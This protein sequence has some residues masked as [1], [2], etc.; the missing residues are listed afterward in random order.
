MINFYLYSKICEMFEIHFPKMNLARKKCFLAMILS[1]LRGKSI[2]KSQLAKYLND[3]VE[4]SSNERR[5]ERFYAE[6]NIVFGRLALLIANLL[7][8]QRFEL[9]LDRSNWEFGG[10]PV[11]ILALTINFYGIGIPVFWIVLPKA[12]NSNQTERI[13]LLEE[14]IELFGVKRI[15]NLTA[16][17]EFI[18]EKWL[19]FLD[20]AGIRFYI[21]IR[22]NMHLILDDK[23]DSPVAAKDLVPSNKYRVTYYENVELSGVKGQLA[24]GFD[25]S[26]KKS[27]ATS[28]NKAVIEEENDYLIVF[29]ND[30]N[31]CCGKQILKQYRGR[32]TIEVSFQCMKGRGFNVENSHMSKPERIE[33]LIAIIAVAMTWACLSGKWYND[34]IR[35]IPI[36]NHGYKAKSFFRAGLDFWDKS[37]TKLYLDKGRIIRIIDQIVDNMWKNLMIFSSS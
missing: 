35:T 18:G 5:I 28:Q 21:R 31:P 1:L 4:E 8:I 33:K 20:E 9:S 15:K 34:N 13:D 19:N 14:F 29:T 23:Q 36:R 17:R 10:Q 32:W 30:P 27:Q 37:W 2:S 7:P 25:K 12:G 26:K 16:D 11:N 3:E 22:A 24:C 6:A